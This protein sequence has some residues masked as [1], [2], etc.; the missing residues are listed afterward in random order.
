MNYK[1]TSVNVAIIK[2]NP[3]S[4]N[5]NE[6]VLMTVKRTPIF[7]LLCLITLTGAA[8]YSLMRSVP[9]KI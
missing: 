7:L 1:R 2:A 5:V 9:T 8:E 3:E 4:I 6:G